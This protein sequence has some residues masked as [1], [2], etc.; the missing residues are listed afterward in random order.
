MA[1]RFDEYNADVVRKQIAPN[2]TNTKD[3]KGKPAPRSNLKA[4]EDLTAPPGVKR[5]EISS[6]GAGTTTAK[7]GQTG[8]ATA[9]AS[10][11]DNLS[12]RIEGVIPHSVDLERNSFRKP[13]TCKIDIRFVDLPFDPRVMRSIAVDVYIGTVSAEEFAA[14]IAGGSRDASTGGTEPLN[15]VADGYIDE[16]GNQRSNLRFEGWVDAYEMKWSKDGDQIVSLECRDSTA[17]LMLIDVPTKGSV[18]KDKPIDEAVADYLSQFPM[19]EGLIIEYRP[20]GARDADT[21]PRLGKLLAKTAFQPHIGPAPAKGGGAAGGENLNVWDY[22]TDI[23]GAIG[24][25]IRVEGRLIIIQRLRDILDGQAERRPDDPYRTRKLK[26]RD[27][28]N[29]TMIFGRNIL[30]LTVRKEFMKKAPTNIQ[31]NVYSTR[32]KKLLRAR[33]PEKADA[34]QVIARPGADT[35]DTKWTVLPGPPGIEDEKVLKWIAE[36]VYN[37][38]GR[39]EVQI[40]LDTEN[41]S[42]FGGGNEDPDLL[43]MLPG[44]TIE[45][46]VNHDEDYS[47]ANELTTKSSIY[48][49]NREMMKLLGYDDGTAA[50]YAKAYTDKNFQRLFRL[51]EAKFTWSAEEGISIAMQLANYIEARA[52]RPAV[53]GPQAATNSALAKQEAQRQQ[54]LKRQKT[55]A[56]TIPGIPGLQG[57]LPIAKK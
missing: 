24:H 21:P 53:D 48:E 28:P 40:E 42:S 26:S 54:A 51:R 7:S 36:D 6:G 8:G 50:G 23:A 27:Y 34:Q 17:L 55:S 1:V 35:T 19:L 45:L 47:T 2:T 44:D 25:T 56:V 11:P 22:L 13:D 16:N 20:Q 32:R 3:I 15:V 57:G 12:F 38:L 10:S 31:I 30:N 37:S 4:V 18:D 14:G 43:D 5:F 9:R 52:N 49:R 41:L 39:N 46:L 29:R 33:F